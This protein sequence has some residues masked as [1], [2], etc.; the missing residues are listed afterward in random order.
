MPSTAPLETAAANCP[1]TIR[2]D[3]A[4]NIRIGEFGADA[5]RELHKTI[6]EV[7]QQSA[8][9]TEIMVKL[10]KVMT[11]LTVATVLLAVVQIA[12][13]VLK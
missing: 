7:N 4:D 12:I 1:R 10:T 8:E 3:M 11:W 13:A 9:Q 5:V 6:K 2:I